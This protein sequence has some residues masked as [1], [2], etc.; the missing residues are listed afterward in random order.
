M[1]NK[2]LISLFWPIFFEILF[3]MLAGS[4][5][6]LML[7]SLNDKAV[8]AVGTAN[9]YLSIF[10]I[11][12]S[13]IS[14]GMVAVMT[15]YIGADKLYVAR[16]AKN[17]GLFL[18]SIFG[19]ILSIVLG[20]LSKEILITVGIAKSLLNYSTT[21]M[22][23]VGGACI[24]TALIP[25]YSNY[26]RS[27]GFI[28]ITM[29]ATIIANILNLILNTLFLYILNMGVTGIAIATVISKIINL[30][31]LIVY[32]EHNILFEEIKY[33]VSNITILKQI[34]K[35]GLPAAAESVLYNLAM[36][37][38][39]RFLNQM[40]AQGINITARAYVS[41]ITNFSYCAGCA[42]AQ[43]NAIIIGWD[44][45]KHNFKKC[46]KGSFK[47]LK[48]GLIISLIISILFVIFASPI[49]AIFTHNQQIIQLASK[50]LI[51]DVFLEM[52][53][54]TNLIFANAL[55]TAGD[56]LYIVVVACI[57]MIL[58]GVGGTY[59]FGIKLEL[60]A[61]G[62][63]IAMA[64]DECIRGIISIFRWKSKKWQEKALI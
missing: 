64:L 3:L 47:A 2:N 53:R 14:T 27:F 12:F 16:Q 39:I 13:V 63:Y 58:I 1:N 6:T 54:V 55:K 31:I 51:I 4:V 24:L 50:L 8:G 62:A 25:I 11:M 5:D 28:K 38:I 46:Y 56:A 32:A 60:M 41:T 35:I 61:I 42:I 9:T 29:Y 30:L 33:D 36:T 20:T 7:S 22:R 52:G 57:I 15:Q 18:N 48:I 34:I 49:L 10:I 21:Y 23:I 17:I 44:M 40:D 19:I 59:L 37:L 26:L 45:G 43:A